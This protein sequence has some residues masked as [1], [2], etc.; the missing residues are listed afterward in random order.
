[1]RSRTISASSSSVNGVKPERSA[2][3]TVTTRRS[4]SDTDATWAPHVEQN[5]AFARF[6]AWQAGQAIPSSRSTAV[7]HPGQ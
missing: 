7:P 2:K 6:V 5:R 3:S 4:A 1:M